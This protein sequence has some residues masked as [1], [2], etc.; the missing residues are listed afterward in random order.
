MKSSTSS[1]RSFTY[2]EEQEKAFP[3]MV[4]CICLGL[5][6]VFPALELQCCEKN[7]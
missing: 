6:L 2:L 7:D 1:P 4:C 5:P 3:D